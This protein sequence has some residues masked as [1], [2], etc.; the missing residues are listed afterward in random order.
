MIHARV[1]GIAFPVATGAEFCFEMKS[2]E[3][4]TPRLRV[5]DGTPKNLFIGAGHPTWAETY[6]LVS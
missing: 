2:G 1:D 5:S 6:I 4:H 3:T